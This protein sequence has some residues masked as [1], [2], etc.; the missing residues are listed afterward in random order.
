MKKK[1]C[2]KC[3]LSPLM[4]RNM[5]WGIFVSSPNASPWYWNVCAFTSSIA[6]ISWYVDRFDTI[7]A[8]ELATSVQVTDTENRNKERFILYT[9]ASIIWDCYPLVLHKYTIQNRQKK[10]S[11]FRYRYCCVVHINSI[12][13]FQIDHFIF[14]MMHSIDLQADRHR[15]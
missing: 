13:T 2:S 3:S 14:G 11:S 6:D 9:F 1:N 10:I 15:K 5:L 12:H 7:N 4:S 8:K